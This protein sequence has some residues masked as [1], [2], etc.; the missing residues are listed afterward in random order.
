M[1]RV[2]FS[3]RATPR[4]AKRKHNF[5]VHVPSDGFP[6]FRRREFT[7]VDFANPMNISRATK[8]TSN[9]SVTRQTIS[10]TPLKTYSSHFTN[11]KCNKLPSPL[12]IA[13]FIPLFSLR[14]GFVNSLYLVKQLFLPPVFV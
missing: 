4:L 13:L 7:R 14:L 11:H 12:I 3:S 5:V 9:V 2:I 6:T 10:P 1:Y 8:K